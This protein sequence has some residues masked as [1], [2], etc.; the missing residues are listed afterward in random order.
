MPHLREDMVLMSRP[1]SHK[2]AEILLLTCTAQ[3]ILCHAERW[4]GATIYEINRR[5]GTEEG[6]GGRGRGRLTDGG[7]RE[8]YDS[9]LTLGA[10]CSRFVL[11][12]T[13][14]QRSANHS[15]TRGVC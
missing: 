12:T 13:L 11:R 4:S 14:Q 1:L 3:E 2:K 9:I 15:R 6:E 7:W 5:S 10:A 8:G